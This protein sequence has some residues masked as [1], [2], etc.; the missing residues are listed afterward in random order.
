M[1]HP[2]SAPRAAPHD[3]PVRGVLLM[4]LAVTLFATMNMFVKLLRA[5]YPVSEI[6]WGRYTFHL[7]F[8]LI[9][10][11]PRLPALLRTANLPIHLLR[12]VLILGATTTMFIAIGFLPL[13]TAI[14]INFVSPLLV[15]ALSTAMLGERVG[16]GRWAAVAIGFTGVLLIIKPGFGG[17]W[18]VLLPLGTALLYAYYQIITRR[19]AAREDPR[20]SLLYLA[21][22]GTAL[23]SV[24]APFEWVWPTA[25]GW[26]MLAA[27]GMLGGIG[28]FLVI[29]AFARA[30]ANVVAPFAYMEIVGATVWGFALFGELPDA[31]TFTGVGMI[32]ACGLW[33]VQSERRLL[34]GGG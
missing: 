14:A 11:G 23:A 12:G 32:V 22:V 25:T 30:H 19:I 13:A 24:V 3:A 31:W 29:Q 4:C 26:L 9:I 27:A 8:A 5:D 17:G 1:T 2:T 21:L 28:H 6:V 33:I 15:V 10:V 7:V 16:A 18:A 20:T 34:A